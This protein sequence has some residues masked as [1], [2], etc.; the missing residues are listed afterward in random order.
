M[1]PRWL[2][3]LM[4]AATGAL[5]VM[6]ILD[7]IDVA[8]RMDEVRSFIPMRYGSRLVI[9]PYVWMGVT[10]YV[11]WRF[12]REE[13]A[14]ARPI[15]LTGAF[16][17]LCMWVVVLIVGDMTDRSYALRH[18]LGY[19]LVALIYIAYTIGAKERSW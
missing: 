2:Y 8:G 10:A 6:H 3:R 12:F 15:A 16:L 17:I 1:T 11:W 9:G 19:P 18:T 4:I 5:R 7:A 13:R 14:G